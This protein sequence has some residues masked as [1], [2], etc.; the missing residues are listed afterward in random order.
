MIVGFAFMP[1]GILLFQ[2]PVVQIRYHQTMMN[3]WKTKGF[4]PQV[5]S[6]N[7]LSVAIFTAIG[8]RFANYEHHKL[9]LL[10]LGALSCRRFSLPHP[11][12]SPDAAKPMAH[13][14][15]FPPP[16]IDFYGTSGPT[17]FYVDVWCNPSDLVEW[18]RAFGDNGSIDFVR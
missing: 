12:A 11:K 9:Q 5:D 1:V 8:D 15:S 18:Q 6:H 10:R 17:F 3:Y 7:V 14:R 13:L 16:H 4:T 2:V